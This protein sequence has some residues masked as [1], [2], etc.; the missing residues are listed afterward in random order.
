MS[1]RLIYGEMFSIDQTWGGEHATVVF[2]NA[3]LP[4]ASWLLT[5]WLAGHANHF[6]G[7]ERAS[8][9]SRSLRTGEHISGVAPG[10][11]ELGEGGMV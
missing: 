8:E 3:L 6:A 11:V 4:G 2:P 9:A 10:I 5:L 7:V 1:P